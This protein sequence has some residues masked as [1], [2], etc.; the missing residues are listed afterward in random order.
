[1][2]SKTT[3]DAMQLVMQEIELAINQIQFGSVEIT[4]PV[5]SDEKDTSLKVCFTTLHFKK[6]DDPTPLSTKADW[7]LRGTATRRSSGTA[8][9]PRGTRAPKPR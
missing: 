1:M 7:A 9:P 4:L 3:N 6:L 2:P 5:P 8:R